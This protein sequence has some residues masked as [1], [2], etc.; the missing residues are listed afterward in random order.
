MKDIDREMH[1]SLHCSLGSFPVGIEEEEEGDMFID[2]YI[3]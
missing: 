1:E 2:I 3:F